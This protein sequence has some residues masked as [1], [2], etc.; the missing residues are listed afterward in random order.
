MRT[1]IAVILAAVFSLPSMAVCAGAPR[2]IAGIRLGAD[3]SEY[4]DLLH[5][6]TAVP[7]RH[8]EYLTEADIRYIP[9]YRGGYVSY[10]N[11][12]EPGRI[13]R[14]KLKYERDDKGFFDQL[15]DQFNRKFGKPAEY[16]GDAFRACIAW[17][18]TFVDSE[19]NRINLILQH[20]CQDDEDYMSGN[21]VKLSM[22][23]LIEKERLCFEARRPEPRKPAEEL[24]EKKFD[25]KYFVPD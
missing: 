19:K 8:S 24:R 18:W 21:A 3:V 12:A 1:M 9:G 20:N 10:A 2:Q 16:R 17:K 25:I 15:L 5:M 23:N 22:R 11:C 7:L 13:A 4:R 14:I 6:D